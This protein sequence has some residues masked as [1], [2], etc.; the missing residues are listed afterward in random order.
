MIDEKSTNGRGSVLSESAL[1]TY[2]N[3]AWHEEQMRLEK[4]LCEMATMVGKSR[5]TLVKWRFRLGLTNGNGR[6]SNRARRTYANETWLRTMIEVEQRGVAEVARGARA[7]IQT[8]EDWMSRFCIRVSNEVARAKRLQQTCLR[9]R[10]LVPLVMKGYP[11]ST[12]AKMARCSVELVV[13]SRRK[14]GLPEVRTIKTGIRIS[15]RARIGKWLTRRLPRTK[16][17]SAEHLVL[18]HFYGVR[19]PFRSQQFIAHLAGRTRAWVQIVRKR[20]LRKMSVR[21]R[22]PPSLLPFF[23]ELRKLPKNGVQNH[24]NKSTIL[25]ESVCA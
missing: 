19:R 21:W 18:S 11:N 24:H 10:W 16:L 1:A 5:P 6:I 20:A 22:V 17:D 25:H 3:R 9:E 4:T 13:L 12:I 8:I 7:S 15:E 23:F 14:L 2:A